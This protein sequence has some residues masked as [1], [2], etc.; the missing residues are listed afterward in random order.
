MA[1]VDH[2]SSVIATVEQWSAATLAVIEPACVSSGQVAHCM[3]KAG[4][5]IADE[6]V[7]VRRHEAVGEQLQPAT[8]YHVSEDA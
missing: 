7:N 3:W 4:G 2:R 5:R 1:V 6:E 8:G